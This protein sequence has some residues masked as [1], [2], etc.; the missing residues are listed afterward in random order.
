MQ[1]SRESAKRVRL[2]RAWLAFLFINHLK[3]S[4]KEADCISQQFVE[5]V[6]KI[7]SLFRN[8]VVRQVEAAQRN[9]LAD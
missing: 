4:N 7:E 6:W 5:I 3:L 1:R 2:Y 9:V 8:D